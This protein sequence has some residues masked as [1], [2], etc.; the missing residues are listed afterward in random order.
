MRT[1]ATMILFTLAV[2]VLAQDNG[3]EMADAMV[4]NGKIYIV[5]GVLSIIL[6]G[7]VL[8]LVA[9]DRRIGKMEKE[10]NNK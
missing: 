10:V 7:I 3:I 4:Q 9:L 6:V 5:I 8:Y 1:I 2:P